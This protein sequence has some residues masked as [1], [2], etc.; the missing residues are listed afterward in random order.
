MSHKP[1]VSV[2]WEFEV[3]NQSDSS[4]SPVRF[5]VTGNYSVD[6]S[7]EVTRTIGGM[8]LLSEDRRKLDLSE[9]TIIPYLLLDGVRHQMSSF[10]FVEDVEQR[11]FMV[12]QETGLSDH[13]TNVALADSS[14]LFMRNDGRPE[15]LY[16]GFSPTHELERMIQDAGVRIPVS[17]EADASANTQTITWDGS[18]TDL[19]KVKQLAELAGHQQPW[20]DNFGIMRSVLASRIFDSILE[21]ERDLFLADTGSV[22]VTNN[23][24]TIPNRV[25]VTSNS[26][27]EYPVIGIWNAPAAWPSSETRRKYVRT[28]LVEVQGVYS[29]ADAEKIAASIGERLSARKLTMKVMPTHLLDGPRVIRYDGSLWTVRSWSMGTEPGAV[30]DLEAEERIEPEDRVES[31][32]IAPVGTI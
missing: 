27:S 29:G 17:V 5:T 9:A 25:I 23:Y 13:M 20:L 11:D 10:V 15:T 19:A 28:Q 8:V 12:D 21:L 3:A 32:P 22:T 30:V 26:S 1:P 6:L 31:A 2:G 4:R 24:L 18:V 7:R 16:A 14:T